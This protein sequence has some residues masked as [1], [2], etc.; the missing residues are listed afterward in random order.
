MVI[1][2]VGAAAKAIQSIFGSEALALWSKYC[3]APKARF[4]IIFSE[5][6]LIILI[7][8]LSDVQWHP[9]KPVVVSVA[10]GTGTITVWAQ[11]FIIG[12]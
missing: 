12:F 1:T 2:F 10:A 11:V 5:F 9:N 6:N 4:S 7:E 3:M 8:L